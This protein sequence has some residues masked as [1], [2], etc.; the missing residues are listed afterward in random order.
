MW[1]SDLLG[2]AS[3]AAIQYDWR[4]DGSNASNCEDNF[5]SVEQAPT[6]DPAAP[7]RPKPAFRAALAAQM[8]VG[9]AESFAGRRAAAVDA[10]A[11]AANVSAS[12]DVFVL[13]FTGG[14]LPQS[15]GFA[16]YANVSSCTAAAGQ[17]APCGSGGVGNE[18]AC[19]AE[20]CCYVPSSAAG[21]GACYAPPPIGPPA[22]PSDES[23]RNDCGFFHITQ[24]QCVSQR[25]CCWADAPGGGPQCF[26]PIS[27]GVFNAS[28]SVAPSPAD[29][30]F[31]VR[32][33][34]GFERG[35]TCA[36][37]GVLQL[38]VSDGPTY[39]F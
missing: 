27:G 29:A 15:V 18:T 16:V 2:G 25:G 11:A 31:Q 38:T 28:F 4:D 30:C 22:C 3:L 19:L 17:Q 36:V 7:F 39:L 1:F 14:T 33:V 21:A 8:W 37:G 35:E 5:G 26:Y 10:A 32:D 12:R 24:A 23:A 13:A 6:G 34:F 9:G 20:G